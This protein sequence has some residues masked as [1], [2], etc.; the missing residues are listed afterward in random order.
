MIEVELSD[1]RK[2]KFKNDITHGQIRALGGQPDAKDQLALDDYM[3]RKIIAFSHE[4]VLTIDL[5]D[6]L[7]EIDYNKII[8][9]VLVAHNQKI[10]DFRQAPPKS[11]DSP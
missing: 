10:L 4:P 7:G 2:W 9:D 3:R 6:A 11:P 1:G 8:I 5:L